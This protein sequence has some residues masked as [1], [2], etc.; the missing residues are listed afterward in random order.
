[1]HLRFDMAKKKRRIKKHYT[2]AVTSDNSVEKTKYY[3]SRFN[4]F[5][6]STLTT[7][8]IVIIGVCLTA[9]EFH[10]IN[11]MNSKLKELKDIISEQD[12]MITELKNDKA[13][14][15]SRNEILDNTIAMTL[16]EQEKVKEEDDKKHLPTG[17]PLTGSAKVVDISVM[18]EPE[19]EL[20]GHFNYDVGDAYT[21]E[22]EKAVE[23][24]PIAVF[25][26]STI[27]DVVATAS[28][29]VISVG[30]D[31]IFTRCVTIDHGNGY[32]T[33]YRNNQDA[34]VSVGDE[35]VKGTILFV[36]G[37]S[38]IYLGYQITYEGEYVD[39]F[40]VISIE[41]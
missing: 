27:S 7:V 15:T 18:D 1:M 20:A 32:V 31:D 38:N 10:E 14:L 19:E 36:G 37:D 35:V 41:G 9:F 25:E 6:V 21:T 29:T 33:I 13:E 40:D 22:S 5:K 8:L 4:I 24:N 12:A 23:E 34:K 16:E 30:E 39:P 2:I 28:G 11:Q 17:F 26:M 3:R